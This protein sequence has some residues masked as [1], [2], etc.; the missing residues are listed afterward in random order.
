M[1]INFQLIIA[2]IF[3]IHIGFGAFAQKANVTDAALLMK[4]YNP[5]AGL[6]A[7]KKLLTKAKDFIDLAAVNTETAGSAKMHMYRGEIYFGLIEVAAMESA[8]TGN[9]PDEAQLKEFEAIARASFNKVLEDPKK[10]FVSD[11]ESFLNFRSNMYFNMGINSYETKNFALATQLF[12]EALEVKSFLNEKYPDAEFNAHLCLSIT[13]DSLLNVKSFDEALELANFVYESMPQNI[14]ILIQLVKIN[15]Q[16]GN[17]VD[18]E[19]YLNEVLALNPVYKELYYALGTSYIRLHQ[20]E[21]AENA[22]TKALFIDSSYEDAQFQLGEH[23]FNWANEIKYQAGQL[24]YKDPKT[25]VLEERAKEMLHRSKDILEV[26]AIKN[27]FEKNVFEILQKLYFNL[28]NKEKS[29]E[30]KLRILICSFLDENDYI[31]LVK[32][33]SQAIALYPNNKQLY[34]ILGTA[35]MDLDENEKAD[36]ALSKALEIDPAYNDAQYQLGAHLYNW[37]AEMKKEAG[38]LPE[39]DASYEPLMEKATAMQYR[40]LELL[41]K[42]IAVNPLDKTVLEILWSTYLK[43]GNSEKASEYKK[44]IEALKN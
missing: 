23:L 15:L 11:I 7:S 13:V 10:E 9:K 39:N 41:E 18:F 33:S 44:R 24:D 21:K 30:H 36:N 22:L 31:N 2:S 26:Y 25:P 1:R 5:M 4:K 43:L 20:Y 38:Q 8:S 16:S 42:Y 32:Y 28:G 40:S 37:A 34:Y 19:K 3:A 29:D 14:D 35:Y 12:V 27:E 6:D 17:I